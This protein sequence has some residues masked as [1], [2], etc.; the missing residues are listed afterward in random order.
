MHTQRIDQSLVLDCIRKI[1]SYPFLPPRLW[2]KKATIPVHY[3]SW[4]RKQF[5]ANCLFLLIHIKEGNL[6]V[7]RSLYG[8]I[9]TVTIPHTISF[10]NAKGLLSTLEKDDKYLI[11]RL[12]DK[13]RIRQNL[14]PYFGYVVLH[15]NI[16]FSSLERQSFFEIIPF[17]T[18]YLT[19][20]AKISHLDRIN[21]LHQYSFELSE[22]ES[23]PGTILSKL[24]QKSSGCFSASLSAYCSVLNNA[25]F[26]EYIKKPSN[27]GRPKC[28]IDNISGT[29]PDIFLKK[30]AEGDV[31]LWEPISKDSEIDNLFSSETIRSEKVPY[32]CVIVPIKKADHVIG[33]FAYIITK[34]II[35]YDQQTTFEALRFSTNFITTAC[36]Y[37]FQRRTNNM[38]V[39]P[40]FKYRSKGIE[41]KKVFV[42]MP[43]TESW[44]DR[45]WNQFIKPICLATGMNPTRADDLYGRDIMEDIWEGI[46][47]SRLII[48]DITGRNPNVFYE[49][50]LAHTIGKEVIL[51]TQNVNDIPFD[52]NRYRHIIYQDNFDGYEIL[53]KELNNSITALT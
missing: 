53:K 22:S 38:L 19:Y 11:V 18:D 28:I 13:D 1:R 16:S 26:L 34:T 29:I 36:Q 35:F 12:R 21:S 43:F 41:P 47:T 5:S 15:R 32:F 33:F 2:S 27:A 30:L 46:C 17:L 39:N 4:L 49:L 52:L 44:S 3:L 7:E 42:L 37:I 31:F 14:F 51:L 50:G 48:A 45:I 20:S 9:D 8:K 40:I 25:F 6:R 23:K 24:I 10:N